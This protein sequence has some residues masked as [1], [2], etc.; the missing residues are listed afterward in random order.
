MFILFYYSI[1]TYTYSNLY[2]INQNVQGAWSDFSKW[3]GFLFIIDQE[4]LYWFQI[5]VEL[6]KLFGYM[7]RLH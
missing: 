4:I 7:K 1:E 5:S 3:E 6:A 2:K